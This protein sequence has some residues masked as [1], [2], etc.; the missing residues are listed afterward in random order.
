[1]SVSQR[2]ESGQSLYH[3]VLKTKSLPVWKHLREATVV[4][5]QYEITYPEVNSEAG[6]DMAGGKSL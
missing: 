5:F 4:L 6:P 3:M 2:V 1:M